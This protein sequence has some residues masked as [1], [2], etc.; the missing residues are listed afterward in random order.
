MARIT[1]TMPDNIHEKVLKLAG[2]EDDSISYTVT[3]LLEIGLMVMDS[4]NEKKNADKSTELEDYCQKI[5][6][7]MNGII[8]EIAIDKF[9]FNNEKITQITNDTLSK[10]NKLKGIQHESL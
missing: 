9:D 4:K 2:K 1:V 7:Q 10:F 8:K 3:R 6:I 5:I